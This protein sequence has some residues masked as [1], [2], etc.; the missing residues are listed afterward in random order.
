MRR[1][2]VF[3]YELLAGELKEDEN[4]YT[5][6]YD[7]NYLKLP[8][9]EAIS[10]TLP[11]SNKIYKSKIMFPFFDGLIPEGWLLQI[12]EKNWKLNPRDRMGL[13]LKCC[14]DCIGAVSI[15]EINDE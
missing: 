4:G 7:E 15:I 12:A 3:M 11:I 5:F 13:L 6:I 2:K 9:K 14:K 10:L 8:N 1:A